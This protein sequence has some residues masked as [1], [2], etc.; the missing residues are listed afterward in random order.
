MKKCW[1]RGMLRCLGVS[2][3]FGLLLMA[4]SP[5]FAQEPTI[6]GVISPGEW[7]D[8][9]LGQQTHGNWT[10]GPGAATFDVYGYRTSTH[11][12]LA[13]E[14]VS[15]TGT[16]WPWVCQMSI[17]GPNL[18]LKSP[19]CVSW[20]ELGY[21]YLSP[22]G[23]SCPASPPEPWVIQTDGN[24]W[25]CVDS[26]VD[27]GVD[28]AITT[29]CDPDVGV[30]EYKIPWTAFS[31]G[32][33]SPV[34][35]TGQYWGY[36]VSWD[37]LQ[38]PALYEG[39]LADCLLL[40]KVVAPSEVMV[41][42]EA[43]FTIEVTNDC[44]CD[45]DDV[46]VTDELGDGLTVVDVETTQGTYDVAGQVVTV[47]VGTVAAGESVTITITVIVG[48][49]GSIENSALLSTDVFNGVEIPASTEVTVIV[50]EEFVPE[51]GSIALLGSGLAGLAGYAALRWRTRR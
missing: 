39:S 45:V 32:A 37:E 28:A 29:T 20:P 24:D 34:L 2:L 30:A 25:A 17:P 9:Y 42:D 36:N 27:A 40:S 33:H 7:D 49:S 1:R 48:G 21:T 10:G 35:I 26:W 43:K 51:F 47:D 4:A 12:F 16:R 11:L 22:T 18:Y 19:A 3:I 31:E 15:Y 41:G 13:L 38:P 46:V 44:A 8:H 5:V 6:D 50:E 23:E 14:M